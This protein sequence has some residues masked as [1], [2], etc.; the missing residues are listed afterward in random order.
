MYVS[1]NMSCHIL[2][3]LILKITKQALNLCTAMTQPNIILL[4]EQISNNNL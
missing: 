1:D 4:A 3:Q 2:I